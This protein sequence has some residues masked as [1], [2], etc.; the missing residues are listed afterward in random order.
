VT[1]PHS[2]LI[3]RRR[4]AR[5]GCRLRSQ[6]DALRQCNGLRRRPVGRSARPLFAGKRW[7]PPCSPHPQQLPPAINAART[8]RAAHANPLAPL[9]P[10]AP[11]PPRPPPPAPATTCWQ[12]RWATT[13]WTRHS[14]GSPV[15]GRACWGF[16]GLGVRVCGG[17][18]RL[19]A[20]RG[21]AAPAKGAPQGGPQAGCSAVYGRQAGPPA[22]GGGLA[23]AALP[24]RSQRPFDR[25]A[26]PGCRGLRRS[27]LP[28]SRQASTAP[29]AHPTPFRIFPPS[30]RSALRPP[31]PLNRARP[32]PTPTHPTPGVL[33]GVV[34]GHHVLLPAPV[35]T[36]VRAR[37]RLGRAARGLMARSERGRQAGLSLRQAAARRL[38]G[39]AVA[40]RWTDWGA[41]PAALAAAHG[42]A[43]ATPH[44]AKPSQAK[45]TFATEL[46]PTQ[47]YRTV[48]PGGRA[49]NRLRTTTG[50]PF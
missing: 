32:V 39:H 47:S 12:R 15:R 38:R 33:C 23:R 27:P 25:N 16:T 14:R 6:V 29:G 43:F 44:Q 19:G 1:I 2:L 10:L 41:L 50:Q 22:V 36:Q 48:H 31:A 24:R 13:Q 42:A 4:G 8:S 17:R 21:G 5:F 9:P 11:S 30:P 40:R 49:Y 7:P 3:S 46:N 26:P 37:G 34:N 20:G 18:A 45:P 35:V 28:A